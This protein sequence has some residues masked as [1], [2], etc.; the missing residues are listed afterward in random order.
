MFFV[1]WLDGGVRVVG[2]LFHANPAF[3][4][5]PPFYGLNAT[6]SEDEAD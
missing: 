2:G 3:S 4:F 6:G 1:P 5:F